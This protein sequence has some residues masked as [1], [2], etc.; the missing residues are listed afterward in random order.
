MEQFTEFKEFIRDTHDPNKF[1]IGIT[2][3]QIFILISLLI[4]SII[5]KKYI[6]KKKKTSR[7]KKVME[8]ILLTR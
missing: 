8:K 3:I 1:V 2:F 6:A 7:K 4:H 5:N